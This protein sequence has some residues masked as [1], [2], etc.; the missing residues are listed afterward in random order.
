MPEGF[1]Q[2]VA[3][4]LEGANPALK[5][6]AFEAF[7]REQNASQV[8]D[9]YKTIAPVLQNPDMARL[10]SFMAQDPELAKAAIEGVAG[11]YKTRYGQEPGFAP[12]Q[13]QPQQKVFDIPDADLQA[14][15]ELSALP[16]DKLAEALYEPTGEPTAKGL[17]HLKTLSSIAVQTQRSLAAVAPVLQQMKTAI[18]EITFDRQMDGM[19]AQLPPELSGYAEH[20]AVI[21]AFDA[22]L[23]DPKNAALDVTAVFNQA[24][25]NI[26]ARKK[27]GEAFQAGKNAASLEQQSA[28]RTGAPPST[29][30][31][32]NP[33]AAA[34]A[35]AFGVYNRWNR[36]LG[37]VTVK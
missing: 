30:A 8:L 33:Q 4:L 22:A 31:P 9:A 10:V 19:L 18:Q 25:N 12:Q 35:Q 6:V 21:T 32:P 23:Q 20:Q 17:S 2:E 5:A 7:K 13:Q 16:A 36:N 29:G 15:T 37:G 11:A 3:T 27:A 28:A 24:V 26:L 1:P 14:L 34:E